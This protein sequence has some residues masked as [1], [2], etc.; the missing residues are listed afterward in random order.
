MAAYLDEVPFSGIIRIR[1]MMYSVD[2]PFRLD[3]G[4]VSFDAPASVKAALIQ[5]V[6]DNRSH[7]V[8]TTGIPPLL[9]LLAN[10]LRRQNHVPVEQTDEVMVASGGI[11]GLFAVCHSLLEPGDEVLVPDPAWPPAA[12]TIQFARAV[13]V[14]Y[15]LHESLRLASGRR[16]DARPHHTQDA[17]DLRELAQQPHGRRPHTTRSRAHRR[18]RPRAR[19]LGDFGRGLRGRDF[20]RSGT[21]QHRVAARD[22]P[23]H[24]SDLHLQQDLRDDRAAAWVLRR[25]RPRPPRAAAQGPLLHR[26][27]HVVAHPVRRH[28]RA[29]RIAGRR[30]RI[31]ARA[32]G[33]ARSVLRGDSRRGGGDAHR[34]AAG[35]RLLRVPEDRPGLAVADARSPGVPLLGDG[36]VSDQTRAD[37]L[38]A[39]RRL[40]PSRRGLRALLFR[41]RPRGARRRARLDAIPPRRERGIGTV[42]T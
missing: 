6:H 3:Q 42:D 35:W 14:G 20:R 27:Q 13:P 25:R 31:P 36:G 8:Q 26:L 33:A 11:H 15:P 17:G 38:R 7:Y 10:K 9:E 22:V 2:R 4:D 19:S 16:R 24:D 34:P 41:T 39:R 21:R 12:G 40:R 28:R 29:R 30:R 5:G 1:D 32:G 18:S 23:A 37:R